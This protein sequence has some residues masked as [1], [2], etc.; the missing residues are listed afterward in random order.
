MRVTTRLI[1]I[2]RLFFWKL[3]NYKALM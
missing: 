2:T 1:K 3:H